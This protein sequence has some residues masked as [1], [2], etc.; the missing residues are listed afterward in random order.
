MLVAGACAAT[1]VP[2]L[3]EQSDTSG[4]NAALVRQ[5]FDS[6]AAGGSVFDPLLAPDVRWTINGSGSLAG[7]CEG[8]DSFLED[9]SL[10]LVSRLSSPVVPD[11]HAIWAVEDT[12]I[13]RFDGSATTTSGATC[14][15]Q[16]VWIF[17]LEDERFVEAEVFLDLA[18][19]QEVVENNEPV[20]D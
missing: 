8:R 18:A 12:A 11:V 17:R 6:W 16:F 2:A 3:A 9:A 5:V 20:T 14:E 10:S 13:V 15:N 7:T 19:Y 4:R 1:A